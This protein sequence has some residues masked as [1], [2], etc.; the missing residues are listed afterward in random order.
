MEMSGVSPRITSSAGVRESMIEKFDRVFQYFVAPD[1]FWSITGAHYFEA[2]GFDI[3]YP[4]L[5]KILMLMMLFR[6]THF[7][8]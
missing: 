2:E 6:L 5:S 4:L 1:I 7:Y 8:T 3:P